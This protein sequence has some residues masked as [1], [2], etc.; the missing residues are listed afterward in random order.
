LAASLPSDPLRT[1]IANILCIYIVYYDFARIIST[2]TKKGEIRAA[3]D[4]KQNLLALVGSVLRIFA[5]FAP[6]GCIPAATASQLVRDPT[7]LPIWRCARLVT[8]KSL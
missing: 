3:L 7:L 2:L 8:I 5:R 6:F 4:L 1:N